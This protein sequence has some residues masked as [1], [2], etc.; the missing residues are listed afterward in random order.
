M[1]RRSV[2]IFP[3]AARLPLGALRAAGAPQPKEE[4]SKGE[5]LSVGADRL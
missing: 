1:T 2:A 3:L 5:V 4:K